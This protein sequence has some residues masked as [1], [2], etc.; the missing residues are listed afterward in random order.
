MPADHINQGDFEAKVTQSSQ[1]VLLDFYADWCGPCKLSAPILDKLADEYKDKI[2]ILKINVDDNQELSQDNM[3]MSIPT[4]ILY[5]KGK[6]VD[7][8]IGFGGEQ[9]YRDML[10]K[11]AN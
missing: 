1:P 3:V 7:R 4:V 10:D 6:E 9:P 11:V 5:D 2:T 8:K